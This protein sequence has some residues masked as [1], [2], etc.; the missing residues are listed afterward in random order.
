MGILRLIL[1]AAVAVFWMNQGSE[2]PQSPSGVTAADMAAQ[3][4]AL[5]AELLAS[6]SSAESDAELQRLRDELETAKKR[7]EV[8]SRARPLPNPP[9]RGSE[10][11]TVPLMPATCL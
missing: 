7:E 8:G 1:V 4:E 3:M 11:V 2:S 6:G 10:V 9:Q 5:K